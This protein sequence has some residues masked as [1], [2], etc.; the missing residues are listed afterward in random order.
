MKQSP[1][2]WFGQFSVA[3]KQYGFQQSNWDHTLIL[4]HW[5]GKIIALIIY[6]DDMIITGDDVEEISRLQ[7]SLATE[8]EIK[9]LVWESTSDELIEQTM[10]YRWYLLDG[11][12]KSNTEGGDTQS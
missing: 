8:F 2:A 12:P 1:H 5:L 4:K 3:M 9:N 7:K 10:S 11:W 6:L